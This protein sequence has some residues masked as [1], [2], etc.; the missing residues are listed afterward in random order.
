MLLDIFPGRISGY[1]QQLFLV[2]SV[3][4]ISQTSWQLCKGFGTFYRIQ[5]NGSVEAKRKD[6]VKKR[7]LRMIYSMGKP[8][9]WLRRKTDQQKS[10]RRD[11]RTRMEEACVWFLGVL[12]CIFNHAKPSNICKVSFSTATE[13][14]RYIGQSYNMRDTNFIDI[15][16]SLA[17]RKI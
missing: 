16:I 17:W 10:R 7:P 4:C 2:N 3:N 14:N 5:D 6:Y 8:K 15:A 13:F 9:N 11:A 1:Q 12:C